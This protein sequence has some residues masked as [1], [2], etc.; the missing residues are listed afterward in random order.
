VNSFRGPD[1][2]GFLSRLPAEVQEQ[3]MQAYRL[4][5]V[6]PF[7]PSLQFKRVGTRRHDW[8]AR[9]GLHYRAIGRREHD[10]IVWYWIGTHAEY[11]QLV[12]RLR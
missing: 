2:D 7:H 10:T 9:V 11:D 4:F 3:A 8:S 6:D 5:E 12:R 1:F